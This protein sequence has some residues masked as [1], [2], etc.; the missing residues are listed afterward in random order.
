[1][2]TVPERGYFTN[3][4][5]SIFILDTLG[6]EEAARLEFP[7]EGL[8]LNLVSGSRYWA[9]AHGVI[10]LG[11]ISRRHLQSAY[12]GLDML[13][14]LECQYLQMTVPRVGTLMCPIEEGPKREILPS[15]IWGGGYQ[16]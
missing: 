7:A 2:K 11:K 6:Q 8:V 13:L 5:K 15:A 12:A 1:M 4:S 16:R 14:Q 3:P 9:W 10:V